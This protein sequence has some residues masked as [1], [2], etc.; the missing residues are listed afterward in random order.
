MALKGIPILERRIADTLWEME[1][2]KAQW[3]WRGQIW[4]DELQTLVWS[5]NTVTTPGIS[6]EAQ[7]WNRELQTL[8]ESWNTVFYNGFWTRT[9]FG[10]T[11]CRP[12]LGAGILCFTMVFELRRSLASLTADPLWELECC[13]LQWFLSDDEVWAHELQ[14]LIGSWNIVFYNGF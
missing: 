7:T 12:S 1:Y 3:S 6:W 14:T 9:K 2:C 8:I 5:L 11:H 4:K 10:L 13:V